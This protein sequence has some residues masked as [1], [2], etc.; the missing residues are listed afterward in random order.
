MHVPLEFMGFAVLGAWLVGKFL[1]TRG[2]LTVQRRMIEITLNLASE[3]DW[4]LYDKVKKALEAAPQTLKI[5]IVGLGHI[6]PDAVL[7]IYDLLINRGSSI[8]LHVDVKTSLFD[9]SLLLVLPAQKMTF[10]ANSW[11]QLDSIKKI[12]SIDWDY[13]E[14]SW[15]KS[16]CQTINEPAEV[17]DYRSVASILNE[18]LPLEEIADRRLPLEAT[19][20]E[21]GLIQSEAEELEFQKMFA[22]ECTNK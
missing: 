12:N 10:R 6:Q 5:E 21:Y 20:K 8:S 14:N 22:L 15:R 7:A 2:I 1:E 16:K 4:S 13:H 3:A 17:T 19:L 11:F 18:F 9:G